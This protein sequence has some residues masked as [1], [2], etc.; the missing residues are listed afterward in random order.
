MV[1]HIAGLLFVSIAILGASVFA[2]YAFADSYG[3][4]TV[5]NDLTVNKLVKNPITNVF[6][7][8]LGSNDPTFSPGSTITYRLYVK[9]GSGETMRTTLKDT[10][11]QYLSFES[12][13]VASSYDAANKIVTMDL[14]DMI[15]GS[16][17]TIEVKAKVANRASFDKNHTVFCTTNYSKVTS[18][19]RPNGDDDTA[20][21]CITTGT[22][23][24]PVAG[25]NDIAML[26][27]FLSMGGVGTFLLSRKQ[28]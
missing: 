2:P 10:L 22:A 24:L 17:K 1:K 28:K 5:P 9:N 23:H 3:T 16:D 8:N 25:V 27:P 18:P 14:G 20:N 19:A 11:P 13:S 12:A 6:V 21:A 7:E 4:T 15:S 26:I